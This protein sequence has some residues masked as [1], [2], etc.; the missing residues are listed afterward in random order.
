MAVSRQSAS[1]WHA[2]WHAEG[3]TALQSRGPMGRRPKVADDQLAAIEQALV[4][5][6]LGHGFA[7]DVWTLEPSAV[8]GQGP[9]NRTWC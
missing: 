6:A 9:G 7:T 8:H 4:E 5:G 1:R 3:T 2:G